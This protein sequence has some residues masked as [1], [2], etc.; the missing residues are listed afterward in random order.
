M[1]V[2]F[3]AKHNIDESLLLPM[4]FVSFGM[5]FATFLGVVIGHTNFF[6]VAMAT[7][8]GFGYGMLRQGIR[9]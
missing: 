6:L 1:T 2:G 7:L 3:G 9:V 8:W 4:L 5:A